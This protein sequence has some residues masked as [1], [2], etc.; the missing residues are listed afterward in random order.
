[1][2]LRRAAVLTLLV[3]TVFLVSYLGL[4]GALPNGGRLQGAVLNL[5]ALLF[6]G[7]MVATMI[8]LWGG[9][10]PLIIWAATLPISALYVLAWEL[11]QQIRADGDSRRQE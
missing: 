10:H 3:S 1:M 11:Y 7:H 4:A 9:A 5:L 8:L 6:F 2:T